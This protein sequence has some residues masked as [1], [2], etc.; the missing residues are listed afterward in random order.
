MA[1]AILQ[2]TAQDYNYDALTQGARLPQYQGSGRTGAVPRHGESRAAL[3]VEQLLEQ[4][5]HLGQPEA[6]RWRHQAAGQRLL[7][8]RCLGRRADAEGDN[9][10]WGTRCATRACDNGRL[11]Q[12]RMDLDNIVWGTFDR[13]GDNIVWGT[14][15]EADN[16]VWGTLALESDNIVWGTRCDAADCEEM[17]WG[18]SVAQG[19]L[20]NIVWG[21][22]IEADNIVWGTATGEV[23]NIVWGTSS[24]EDNMTWGCSGE[25]T[26]VFD[27]PDVPSVF[28]GLIFDAL[29]GSA[30][31]PGPVEPE[32]TAPLA[33][34][35][36]TT[37]TVNNIL[38]PVNTIL[39]GGL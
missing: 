6:E 18:S 24:E 36:E 35:P 29:F 15:R 1:K 37:T 39:G 23:D 16:I 12:R 25:E 33:I 28:D 13:E 4:G 7:H 10:V 32:P 20:D 31:N 3:S 8:G 14:I 5:D 19:E 30:P 17:V 22:L 38:A 2:Y 34:V 27:D 26:P 9:I 11:G 21:T